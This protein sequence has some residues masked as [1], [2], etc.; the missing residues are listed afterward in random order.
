MN[1]HNTEYPWQ[2][3]SP[4]VPKKKEKKE[5]KLPFGHK[6]H[7]LH[8]EGERERERNPNLDSWWGREEEEEEE[9]EEEDDVN[10]TC[11]PPPLSLLASVALAIALFHAPPRRTSSPP[12]IPS[13]P[14]QIAAKRW[15]S[16]CSSVAN[17]NRSVEICDSIWA[18]TRAMSKVRVYADVNVLRPKDTG[19]RVA[20]RPVG[21]GFEKP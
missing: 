3:L 18:G 13:P 5:E 1:L 21:Y 10:E 14:P 17:S 16:K 11:P 4:K 7:H 20:H 12:P 19:L 15:G 8:K 2:Y 9:E 6:P